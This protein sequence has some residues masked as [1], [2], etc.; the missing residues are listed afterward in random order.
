MS[1]HSVP[2]AQPKKFR[3]HHV[4]Q[5]KEQGRPLTMLTAYDA[6]TARIFEEAGIDMLLVGDSLGNVQLGHATT[7]QVELA[8]MES[9]VAAVAR[10]VRRPMIIAD[11]PFGTYEVGGQHAFDSA[12]RLMKAGAHAVK[13][14][15]GEVRADTVKMLVDGGIP[16]MGHLGYTPQ[17]ENALGGPRMQG[18]G[19][20]AEQRM[21]SDALA[22]QEAGAFAIVFEMV[23]DPVA[24][25]LTEELRVPTIGIGAGPHTDGQVLVWSDM[26]GMTDWVP[27]FVKRFGEVGKALRDAA[28]DYIAE[29]QQRSF[30]GP[31]NYKT[32]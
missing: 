5:A 10:T 27:S 22:L 29:V 24:H 14:E 23:P 16:V 32:N 17:S 8:D 11:L 4:A 28:T 7:L 1:S 19:E 20:E 6:F 2:E 31:D 13:L 30:P 25:R 15:G 18:R 26:A 12:V 3:I 21:R 9:A